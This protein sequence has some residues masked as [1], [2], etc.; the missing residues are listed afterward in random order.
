MA[1]GRGIDGKDL[2]LF[3]LV[4]QV[5]K[6]VKNDRETTKVQ[7]VEAQLLSE[8][9]REIKATVKTGVIRLE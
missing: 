7:I 2:A 6:T 9:L 4:F 5:L 1:R 3:H 8:Q